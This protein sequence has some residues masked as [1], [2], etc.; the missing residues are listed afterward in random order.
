MRERER[1]RE[2]ER[3]ES[4]WEERFLRGDVSRRVKNFSLLQV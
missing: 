4:M 3:G 2:R 1:E